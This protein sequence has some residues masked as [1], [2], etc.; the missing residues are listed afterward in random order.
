VR[1]L[2][3]AG[4]PVLVEPGAHARLGALLAGRVRAHRAAII[5]DSNV[6]PL[7]AGAVAAALPDLAPVIVTVPAGEQHKTRETWA[8]V[9]DQLLR[10]GIGRD[11]VV[12]ALGGGVVGDLAG[13][14]AATYLRGIPVV[15]VPT[16]LVAMIDAAIGGKTGVD[17]PAGKNLIGAFH[18]AA[19]VLVDADF[20]Q[21]LPPRE[22]RC[23][24]AEALKHGAVA[25]ATYFESVAADARHLTTTAGAGSAKLHALVAESV[26]I[27]A[28]VVNDDPRESGRRKIL[29][30]GH[31]LGHAIEAASGYSLRHGEAVAIGMVCEALVGERIG[32]TATGTASTLARALADAGL[33]TDATFDA[34]DLVARTHTDKKKLAGKVE[35]ALPAGIGRFERWT[36]AVDDPVVVEILASR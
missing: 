15:Q 30:F 12:I 24:I 19:L 34:A 16:S 27:K 14:V 6:G 23:G 9:S 2:T 4:S 25:D 8:D 26:A 35:Y 31:T 36:T 10:H 5:T 7:Y 3:A 11:G 22:I 21:S 17:V 28:A 18:P 1:E 13:F 33:P 20:L 29:N 32:A